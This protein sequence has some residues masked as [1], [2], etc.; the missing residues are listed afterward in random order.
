MRIAFDLDDTLISSK[1]NFLIQNSVCQIIARMF[2][3]EHLRKNTTEIFHFCQKN[4][5]ETWV[6]TTSFR[7]KIYIY[8]LFLLNRI[9]LQGIVNQN[10]HAKKVKC[11]ATKYPPA[12]GIDLLVDDS[13]GVR[14]EGK[15]YGFDVLCIKP[16]DKD[17]IEKIKQKI[18]EKKPL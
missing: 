8:F 9:N 11:K 17:W 13:E 18:V 5:I 7:S 12:F 16:D 1:P 14:I 4:N 10:V 3:V 6:Y 2:H 15:K